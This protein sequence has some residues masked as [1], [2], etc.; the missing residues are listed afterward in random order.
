MYEETQLEGLI[1]IF[2]KETRYLYLGI[3]YGKYYSN[4]K[5]EDLEGKT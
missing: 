1:N 2:D 4:T 3:T 5:A